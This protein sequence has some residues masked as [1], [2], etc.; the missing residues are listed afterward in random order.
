MTITL[1]QLTLSGKPCTHT[2]ET[3]Y[4][5]RRTWDNSICS[6]CNITSDQGKEQEAY[7]WFLWRTVIKKLNLKWEVV[8]E[9]NAYN[10]KPIGK[11]NTAFLYDFD[12]MKTES[13][14][15]NYK[16]VGEKEVPCY[17]KLVIIDS[18]IGWQNF[19]AEHYKC[20]TESS[21][22]G[23]SPETRRLALFSI[24]APRSGP[25]SK[26]WFK[27]MSYACSKD[28]KILDYVLNKSVAEFRKAA[29]KNKAT[30][31]A[32]A[33]SNAIKKADK[34]NFRE[35]EYVANQ[36]LSYKV[37]E[38]LLQVGI[39]VHGFFHL[40]DS[41][42]S[43]KWTGPKTYLLDLKNEETFD[44]SGQKLYDAIIDLFGKEKGDEYINTSDCV[45]L[46]RLSVCL[47]GNAV[48]GLVEDNERIRL[49]AKKIL[50]KDVV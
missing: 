37:K 27:V 19:I 30:K 46:K 34:F 3:N 50:Q 38:D 47:L 31:E 41:Q 45:I 29:I 11:V 13:I 36:V 20:S 24:R 18:A 21:T 35:Q 48:V 1:E 17:K 15:E 44:F 10:S 2:M 5:I 22:A 23:T 39:H 4:G 14:Y 8:E 28:S 26:T 12:Y 16:K 9:V 6:L 32:A 40:K 7:E 33:L 25:D 49:A 43:Y 42:L